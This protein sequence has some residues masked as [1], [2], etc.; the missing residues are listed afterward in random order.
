V[1]HSHDVK[2]NKLL[3]LP[4]P[5]PS[6][7]LIKNL[8][9]RV[10]LDHIGG[11]W[12][13]TLNAFVVF[14]SLCEES[15]AAPT[16]MMPPDMTFAV[17]DDSLLSRKVLMRILLSHLKASADSFDMG[18]S[19]TDVDVFIRHVVANEVVRFFCQFFVFM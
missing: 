6:A 8:M 7:S 10:A 3:L 4:T 15:V 5:V 16:H 17:L 18:D 9:T 1:R 13:P 14:P 12:D 19:P 11:Y 2:K